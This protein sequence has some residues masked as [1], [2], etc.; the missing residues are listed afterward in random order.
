MFSCEFCK[1]SKN[2]Y[3]KEHL[4]ATASDIFFEH[5]KTEVFD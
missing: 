1:I 2:T 5:L 4:R 3:F